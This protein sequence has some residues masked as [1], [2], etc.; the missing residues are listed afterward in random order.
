MRRISVR[1]SRRR[2]IGLIAA[3]LALP[4]AALAGAIPT[5]L[6]GPWVAESI[7]RRGVISNV[8]TVIDIAA[9]GKVTGSGGCNRIRGGMTI[10]EARI[11]FSPMISTKMACA[12]AL[13]NQE[14]DF[15][16]ALGDARLW[17]IDEQR[18]KLILVDAHG[19]TVLRLIRM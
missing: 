18:D 8:Q 19:V 17:R 7:R 16:S 13:M 6:I 12:P 11:S 9:D 3:A 15:L 2:F 10:D 14:S 4:E 1:L 5:A